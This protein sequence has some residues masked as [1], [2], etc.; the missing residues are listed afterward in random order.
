MFPSSDEGKETPILL[1]P[2][3]RAN[4]NYWHFET[5][6]SLFLGRGDS[7]PTSNPNLEDH[8]LSTVRYSLFNI[9]EAP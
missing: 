5:V 4:L 2:L 9:I 3:E 1:A 7:S 6:I 8:P